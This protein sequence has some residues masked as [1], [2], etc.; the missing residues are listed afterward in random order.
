MCNFDQEI[1]IFGAKSQFLVMESQLLSTVHIPIYTGLQL[2]HSV[3]LI[4]DSGQRN[5][6]KHPKF[7]KRLIFTCEK[8]TFL[9]AHLF[10]VMAR[11]S[12]P[13]RS[14]FLG[15]KT[16]GFGPKICL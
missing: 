5:K 14:V 13:A 2:S 8:G 3:P 4:L 11:T 1:W 15:P 6:K 9:Y 10:P 12:H 7:A 16:L